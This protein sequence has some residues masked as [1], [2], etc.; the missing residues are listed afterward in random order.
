MSKH[1]SAPTV[2]Y[3][4]SSQVHRMMT[5][6]LFLIIFISF[7][8]VVIIRHQVTRDCTDIYKRD[9]SISHY[10]IHVEVGNKK[11]GCPRYES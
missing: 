1:D 11:V 5:W 4:F 8:A 3:V 6:L 9:L 10:W 2:G 7:V